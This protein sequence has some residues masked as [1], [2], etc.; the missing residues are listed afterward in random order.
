MEHLHLVDRDPDMVETPFGDPGDVLTG[1]ICSAGLSSGP[2]LGKPMGDV[3]A[4]LDG[5]TL[6]F[7]GF[8]CAQDSGKGQQQKDLSFHFMSYFHKNGNNP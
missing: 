1:E 7:D 2:A 5:E 6:F 3:H 8:A 4:F